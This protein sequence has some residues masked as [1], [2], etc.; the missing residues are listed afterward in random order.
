MAEASRKDAQDRESAAS[1]AP[2]AKQ[3]GTENRSM[4]IRLAPVENSDQRV[5]AN[6]CTIN[7]APGMVFI[8]F[9][10]LEP[11]MLAA[12]P[13]VARLGRQAARETERQARGESGAGF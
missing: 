1:A 4:G 5:V 6:Y 9:G 12:L 13:R 3:A 2:A 11:A 7:V 8:D 10:F